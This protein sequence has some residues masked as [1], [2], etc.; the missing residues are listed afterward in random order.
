[1]AHIE[2]LIAKIKDPVLR[3]D[4]ETEIKDL[5][6]RRDWGL[7]FERYRPELT[8]LLDAPIR[9]GSAVWERRSD[10]PDAFVSAR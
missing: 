4:L 6:E 7:V 10:P 8:L 2:D 9:A 1:M 5:K 3:A